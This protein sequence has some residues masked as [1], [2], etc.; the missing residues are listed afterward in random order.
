MNF[1]AKIQS[2]S[3]ESLKN[4]N[5]DR[6]LKKGKPRGEARGLKK[7]PRSLKSGESYNTISPRSNQS[8]QLYPTGTFTNKVTNI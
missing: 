2:L 1:E 4:G 8:V 6:Y 5:V 3:N 7:S